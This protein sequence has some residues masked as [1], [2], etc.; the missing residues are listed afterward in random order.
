M[1]HIRS[2]AGVTLDGWQGEAVPEWLLKRLEQVAS[3]PYSYGKS[4]D[5]IDVGPYKNY[6]TNALL[7]L[8]CFFCVVNFVI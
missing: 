4:L 7:L 2:A 6:Y 5:L 8:A 1:C 3:L